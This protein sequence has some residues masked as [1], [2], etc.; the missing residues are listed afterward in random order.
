MDDSDASVIVIEVP[1]NHFCRHLPFVY[2]HTMWTVDVRST[3]SPASR[4][5]RCCGLNF[6]SSDTNMVNYDIEYV[7][8]LRPLCREFNSL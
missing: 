3:L 2:D 5:S 4:P 8:I 1:C 7:I 6:P